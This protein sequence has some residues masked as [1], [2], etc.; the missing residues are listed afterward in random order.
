VRVIG[1]CLATGEAAGLA[2]AQRILQGDCD[3]ASVNAARM[4]T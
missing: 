2:A 1:T 4:K 3:A